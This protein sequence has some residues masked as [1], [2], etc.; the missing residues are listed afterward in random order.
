MRV[1]ASMAKV[2]LR[3]IFL[4]AAGA[5]LLVCS[6]FAGAWVI[7]APSPGSINSP[8]G[9]YLVSLFDIT[10]QGSGVLVEL[11]LADDAFFS[12]VTIAR[13]RPGQLIGVK[14]AAARELVLYV[15]DLEGCSNLTKWDVDVSCSAVPNDQ[16]A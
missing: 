11:E 10:E 16:E 2:S 6:F 1:R 14:W 12:V 13:L 5:L 4:L 3:T 7:R 9:K 8:D 15:A